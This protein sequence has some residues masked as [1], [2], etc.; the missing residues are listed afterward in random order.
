MMVCVDLPG[1]AQDAVEVDL[2]GRLLT[3]AGHRDATGKEDRR[4]RVCDGSFGP[5]VRQFALPPRVGD[6]KAAAS[7]RDGVLEVRIPK[8]EPEAASVSRVPVG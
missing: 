8:P 2:R 5:F 4:L 1:V 7:L 3:I 6:S